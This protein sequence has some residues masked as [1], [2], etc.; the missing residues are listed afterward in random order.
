MT[1]ASKKPSNIQE[2]ILGLQE[3]IKISSKKK[4]VELLVK[5]KKLKEELTRMN[6]KGLLRKAFDDFSASKGKNQQD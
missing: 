3:E 6:I 4:K 1:E 5:L 2:E